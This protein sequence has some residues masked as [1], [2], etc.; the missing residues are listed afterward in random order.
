M[1]ESSL[2]TFTEGNTEGEALFV[3]HGWAMNSSVWSTIQGE[4]EKSY[5]VTYVDL[6]GHGNNKHVVTNSL[7]QLVDLVLPL[8]E[9]N[10]SARTKSHLMGWSLGGLLIQA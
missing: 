3:F 1:K 8:V 4:L 5:L 9:T 10:K 2:K 6:P 7:N